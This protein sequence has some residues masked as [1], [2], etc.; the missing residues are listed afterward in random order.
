MDTFY[1]PCLLS[2]VLPL[3]KIQK[4]KQIVVK[5]IYNDINN[6]NLYSNIGNQQHSIEDMYDIHNNNHGSMTIKLITIIIIS[7]N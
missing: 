4:I 6:Y 2:Q 7:F 1:C 3:H 5:H